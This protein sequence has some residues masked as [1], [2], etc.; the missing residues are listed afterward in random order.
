VL[1]ANQFARGSDYPE[2]YPI[3][4]DHDPDEVLC[5]GA[6][7][8]V[9][10]LGEILSGPETGGEAILRAELDLGKITEAKYDLDLVGHYNRPDVFRL[11][12]NDQPMPPVVTDRGDNGLVPLRLPEGSTLATSA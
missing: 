7:M 1:L 8:I 10:P 6:S 12:V 3:E 5:R 2:G 11:L 9:S 4:G